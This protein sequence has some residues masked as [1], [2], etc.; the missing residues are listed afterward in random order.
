MVE[1][2]H[3]ELREELKAAHEGLR[4][5]DIDRLEEL[6]AVRFTLDPERDA[7]QLRA[8]DRERILLLQE[9]M[10]RFED[11]YQRF[12]ARKLQQQEPPRGVEFSIEARDP[13]ERQQE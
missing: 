6:I 12:R 7:E 1:P 9:K 8:V 4:D 2:L 3:P 10:P 11:V 13:R 5:S